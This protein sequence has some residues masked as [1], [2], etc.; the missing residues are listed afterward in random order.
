MLSYSK[1]LDYSKTPINFFFPSQIF[2]CPNKNSGSICD[3]ICM[4]S[5]PGS[6]YLTFVKTEEAINGNYFSERS[7]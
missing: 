5:C 2:G 1:R 7:C 3:E 6:A 4:C